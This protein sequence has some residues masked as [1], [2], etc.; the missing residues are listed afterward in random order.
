LAEKTLLE[1]HG[2]DYRMEAWI[3]MPNHVHLVVD[4]W[5]VPLTKLVGHWKGKSS[6]LAN[7]LLHRRG[8]FWR[9]DYFDTLIRDDA[10]S[11]KAIRYT[12]QNAVKAFLVRD[13]REW[14]WCSA[15]HRDEYE[16]LTCSCKAE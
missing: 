3:I 2:R 4:V 5:E 9:E 12:E 6:R 13:T 1:G 7:V 16:R 15:R 14:P 8:Q 11:N 10:H